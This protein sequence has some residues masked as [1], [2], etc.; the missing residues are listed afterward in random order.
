[1]R[2]WFD[3]TLADEIFIESPIMTKMGILIPDRVIV[4]GGKAR[5]IDFKTGGKHPAHTAQVKEYMETLRGMG[6]ETVGAS[7]LYL[8]GKE[9][10]EVAL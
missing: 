1:M 7:I 2:E 3:P 6:Y 5:V 9:I 8:D 4:S 10:V